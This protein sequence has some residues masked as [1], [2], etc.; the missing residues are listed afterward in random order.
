MPPVITIPTRRLRNRSG[1]GE[2]GRETGGA[3]ALDNKLLALEQGLDRS[4][5]ADL[6]DEPDPPNKRRDDMAG[7]PAR[8]LDRDPSAKGRSRGR[9]TRI[10]AAQQAIHRGIERRLDADDLDLRLER[11][12]RDRDPGYQ[13]AAADRHDERVEIRSVGEQ[14]ETRSSPGRR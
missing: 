11:L 3:G 10:F 7:Q 9:R 5:R 14:L 12:G 4:L 13:P 6:V 1:V 8:L 2:H